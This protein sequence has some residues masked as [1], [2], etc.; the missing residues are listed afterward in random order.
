MKVFGRYYLVVKQLKNLTKETV[1]RRS[2]RDWLLQGRLYESLEHLKV[3]NFE[4]IECHPQSHNSVILPGLDSN[5]V[6]PCCWVVYTDHRTTQQ[7]LTILDT[8]DTD[9]DNLDGEELAKRFGYEER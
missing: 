2:L 6:S 4:K 1:D 8:L 7:T 5:Q 3:E 9:V